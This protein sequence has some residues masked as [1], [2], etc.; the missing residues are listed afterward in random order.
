MTLVQLVSYLVYVAV[1]RN[2][3]THT[4]KLHLH[5]FIQDLLEKSIMG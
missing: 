4:L 2:R 3:S 1:E 5:R